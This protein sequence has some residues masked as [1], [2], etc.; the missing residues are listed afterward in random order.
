MDRSAID[1]TVLVHFYPYRPRGDLLY[2]SIEFIIN[3]DYAPPAQ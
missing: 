3:I 2:P 1:T